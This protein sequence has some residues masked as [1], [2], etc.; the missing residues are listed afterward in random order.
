MKKLFALLLSLAMV[1]AMAAC[2]DTASNNEGGGNSNAGNADTGGEEGGDTAGIAAGDLQ[3]GLICIH[4]EN[5]GYDLAHIDGLRTACSE[6]G[7]DESQ[8]TMRINIPETEEC[9]DA[10]IQLADAGCDIIF[11]DSYGHQSYMALAAQDYPEV[12]F[13]ACTGDQAATSGISNLKNIFPYT[14]ESRYV[15]GVVAG[16]KLKELMDAGTVTDPYVGYVGAFPYAEV[17]CGYTAFL[18]GIQSQVPEAHMDVQYTNSWYDPVAEGEAANALMARGCVIIGQHADS[19]GAP[20]AVQAALES[21]TV[22]YSV[23]YNI[24]MLSVAPEAALTSAQ[25]NWSVLYQATL[26]KFIAGE[27]IPADYATGCADGAVMISALG[28][29]CAEGTQEKVDEVWAGIADGSLKVFDTSTFTVGGETVTEYE[30]NFSIIDFNTGTVIYEG[31]TENVISDGVFQES[32]YRS[33]PYFDL[34]IDGITE[35]N[36]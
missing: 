7:I 27:E 19:T 18:L 36:S 34:R 3:I 33:A 9:Y 20:S 29:S 11:S 28:P 13:V 16:M 6:L 32:V 14:Y 26:E 24:D 12:T 5:S 4:D 25:N 15:S 23:G 8:I 2:G 10:A 35:L 21:G 1:F 22:A 30:V 17:V 31:P